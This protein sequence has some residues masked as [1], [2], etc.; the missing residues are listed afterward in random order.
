MLA[1]ENEN[2][3]PPGASWR[4]LLSFNGR[5]HPQLPV[6]HLSLACNHCQHP[7]CRDS[8]PTGVYERDATTGA[9]V[10][11]SERCIGCRYC[12]W[13]CP[14]DAPRFDAA[15][16]IMRK[17][18]F[19]VARQHAG[20]APACAAVCPTGALELT[21]HGRNIAALTPPGFPDTPLLPAIAFSGT[22]CVS[23]E[24]RLTAPDSP[25]HEEG[26]RL[27]G[28]LP[29]AQIS[30][31]SEW[32]LVVFTTVAS[33]LVALLTA[34]WWGGA[35]I[36]AAWFACLAALAVAVSTSHL[37]RRDR[38]WRAVRNW[39]TS[40][41]SREII[42]FGA[43]ATMGALWLAVAPDHHTLGAAAVLF[44][45][46]ALYAV[47]RLYQVAL[48]TGRWNFH[49]AHA[50]LNAAYLLGILA[51]I[52]P[53]ML[54]AGA[55]KLALYGYRKV[56]FHQAGEPIRPWWS[57]ARVVLGFV[58][59]MAAQVQVAAWLPFAAGAAI[60]GDLI[61]RGEFYQ[62][63][64]VVTPRRLL[65]RAL[66]RALLIAARSRPSANPSEPRRGQ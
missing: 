28:E 20:R 38:I 16:G 15:H 6:F 63:M 9:L 65:H 52:L 17:C 21:E 1:C 29:P 61:D 23:H 59:P 54:V 26:L 22:G 4:S 43:F 56:R 46:A 53:L 40:W 44:G 50:L 45:F 2:Q 10:S 32:P 62:E 58:I 5:R 30:F 8:C 47:D 14:Y 34:S 3:L 42:L 31:R 35:R 36:P 41:L 7:A 27:C 51:G 12:S 57:L 49:S 18:D 64:D 55:C 48:H 11:R 25:S 66:R 19:C 13:A 33:A 24:L 60:L 37:G 39:R